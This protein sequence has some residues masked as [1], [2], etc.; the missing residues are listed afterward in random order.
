MLSFLLPVWAFLKRVPWW[1]FAIVAGLALAF[2][3]HRG[4]VRQ[5]DK[6]GYDRAMKQVEARA[7]RIKAKA[8]EATSKVIAIADA[9]NKDERNRADEQART[10]AAAADD[11]RRVRPTPARSCPANPASV[12]SSAGEREATS[13]PADAPVAGLPSEDRIGLPYQRTIDFAEAADLN[14]SEVLSW[15]SWYQRQAEAYEQWRR[16]WVKAGN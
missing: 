14:R 2:F 4:E 16:D 6:R 9:I 13:R 3:W 7:N 11:L 15:R 5:A 12:P 1:V 8:D 10:I